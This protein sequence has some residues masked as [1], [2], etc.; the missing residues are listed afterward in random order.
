M[1]EEK[2]KIIIQNVFEKITEGIKFIGTIGIILFV[3]SAVLSL[4]LENWLPILV[5][6]P[7][8]YV[9]YKWLGMVLTWLFLLGAG[10]FYI[11]FLF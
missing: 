6:F 3:G 5:A 11:I 10:L 7:F 2:E 9:A 1:N 8:V 4:L